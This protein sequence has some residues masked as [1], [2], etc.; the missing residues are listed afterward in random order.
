MNQTIDGVFVVAL[1]VLTIGI[2]AITRQSGVDVAGPVRNWFNARDFRKLERSD[3]R[4]AEVR[5]TY[6][7]MRE[8]RRDAQRYA[9][10]GY[11]VEEELLNDPYEVNPI[12]AEVYASSRFRQ[13]PPPR[14]RVPVARIT[15]R[16]SSAHSDDG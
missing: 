6:W 10:L 11:S 4:P 7:T 14:R 12:V 2:L 1:L 13:R 9:A 5:R 15:Y 3:T 16:A 8:Y